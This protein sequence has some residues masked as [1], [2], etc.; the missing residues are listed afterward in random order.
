[1]DIKISNAI[2][3]IRLQQMAIR[4]EIKSINNAIQLLSGNISA[5]PSAPAIRYLKLD[6]DPTKRRRG[7]PAKVIYVQEDVHEK[8]EKL[9]LNDKIIRILRSKYRFMHDVEL[10]TACINNYASER[11]LSKEEVLERVHHAIDALKSE[12]K[13]IEFPGLD[14]KRVYFGFEEWLDRNGEIAPEHMYI[15]GN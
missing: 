13:I 11:A 15:S 4:E 1:M 12:N 3:F 2:S 7:R 6:D 10:A 5:E 8:K 14:L 9:R